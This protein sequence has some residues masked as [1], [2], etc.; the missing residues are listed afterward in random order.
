MEVL[1]DY[2]WLNICFPL[3]CPTQM[4]THR[5]V[6]APQRTKRKQRTAQ[7]KEQTIWSIRETPRWDKQ[8]N[9]SASLLTNCQIAQKKLSLAPPPPPPCTHKTPFFGVQPSNQLNQANKSG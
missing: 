1:F 4:A 7:K 6:C 2:R 8:D 5:S 3:V 9:L